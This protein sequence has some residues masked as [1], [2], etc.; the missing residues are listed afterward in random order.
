[1]NKYSVLL[2]VENTNSL[3]RSKN[4]VKITVNQ[5][6]FAKILFCDLKLIN[7]FM[8]TN[9]FDQAL[10][11]PVLLQQPYNNYWIVK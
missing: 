8:T 1:M 9:I 11:R 6:L 10:S 5:L 7:W 2:L 3:V 4:Y